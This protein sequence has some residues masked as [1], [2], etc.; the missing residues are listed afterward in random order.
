MR[1]AITGKGF[2]KQA[3]KSQYLIKSYDKGKQ[4]DRPDYILRFE[5]K[6]V[7]MEYLEGVRTLSDLMLIDKLSVLGNLLAEAWREC[8]L[9]ELLDVSQLTPAERHTYDRATNA[10]EWDNLR[11]R[12]ERH[13]LRANYSA[14]VDKYLSGG[15][16][17]EV[18]ELL[19]N[20]WY[21]LL[22]MPESC[23][24]LTDLPTRPTPE[25]CYVL[26]DLPTYP[27]PESCYVLTD[28]P[29]VEMLR[30]DRSN[31]V[32]ECNKTPFL[33][34][35]EKVGFTS[36]KKVGSTA[37]KVVVVSH[38]STTGFS[39]VHQKV[40]S[41]FVGE[42][43][44]KVEDELQ[45]RLIKTRRQNKRKR[46]HHTPDYYGAHNARNDFH[47]PRHNLN[48]RIERAKAQTTLFDLSEVLRLTDAQR[49]LVG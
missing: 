5:V 7:K 25:S 48:K 10:T 12:M 11:D 27:T 24:V 29:N 16:K 1:A 32:S 22:A 46:T 40:G 14:I 49:K 30:F 44:V 38:C 45:H 28:L 23:Y 8:V 2:Y 37:S 42:F 3:A 36:S 31:I 19:Q 47:N 20:K 41:K 34:P 6:V 26:T 15:R 39:I 33:F 13:R 4:Y 43:T 21:D 35:T 17:K 9:V 18:A